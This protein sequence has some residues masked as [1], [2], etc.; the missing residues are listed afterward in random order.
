[1]DV[2]VSHLIAKQVCGSVHFCHECSKSMTKI[3]V[4]EIYAQLALYL[5]GGVFEGINGLNC[6]IGQAIHQIRGCSF[7]PIQ[8]INEPL[9]LL[10]EV[11]ESCFIRLP[12]PQF[13]FQ[14]FLQ[15]RTQIDCS[16]GLGGINLI[17][18]F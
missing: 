4:F 9:L 3:M 16:F 14:V 13:L 17:S 18:P 11:G 7:L 12:L 15:Q 10:A 1:M 2:S 8:V 6:A 5:T